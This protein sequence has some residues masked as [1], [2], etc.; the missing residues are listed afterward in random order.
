MRD[1]DHRAAVREHGQRLLDRRLGLRVE[2]R[3]RFVEH[4]HR[5]VDERDARDRD[6]LALARRE[7]DAA[8]ADVGREP[9]GERLDRAQ[10]ADR[11][12]RLAHLVVGRA[13]RASRT[14]SAIDPGEEM[15]LLRDEDDARAQRVE[16]RVAQV[17]AAER[18]GA[19]LRVVRADEQLRERRLAGAGRADEREVLARLDVE[20]DV[21]DRRRAVAVGERD[22]VRAQLAARGQRARPPTTVAGS[23]SSDEIF[24]S[25]ARPDWNSL[26]QSPSRAT[27]SKSEIR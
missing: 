4:D 15:A 27:G 6:E 23:A 16:R 7:T 19:L 20:R 2:R 21:D 9:V 11:P 5:R 14:L 1:R 24:A 10:R 8:R 12:E 13:G 17:D 26:Y 25:A 3:R 22:A 18:D